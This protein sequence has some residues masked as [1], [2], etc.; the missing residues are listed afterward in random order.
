MTRIKSLGLDPADFIDPPAVV[1]SQQ[2][3]IQ[4]K[5]DEMVTFRFEVKG[6]LDHVAIKGYPAVFLVADSA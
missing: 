4:R 5:Y 6:A 3:D 2:P 1:R